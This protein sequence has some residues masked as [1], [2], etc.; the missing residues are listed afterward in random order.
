[1]IRESSS[2][3]IDVNKF[4][5]ISIVLSCLS[6]TTFIYTLPTKKQGEDK[7][8]QIAHEEKRRPR[9]PPHHRQ[10]NR[11][12]NHHSHQHNLSLNLRLRE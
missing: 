7:K 3:C 4:I 9:N 8:E 2:L 12:R 5:V 6:V 1:M 10:H 11:Q